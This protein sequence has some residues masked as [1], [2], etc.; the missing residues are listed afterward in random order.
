MSEHMNPGLLRQ[1][2]EDIAH[3][4][5]SGQGDE[6]TLAERACGLFSKEIAQVAAERD[7]WIAEHSSAVNLLSD[8]IDR[9]CSA[10]HAK[11]KHLQVL[12]D[13]AEAAGWDRGSTMQGLAEFVGALRERAEKAEA[14]NDSMH[15]VVGALEARVEKAE[16]IVRVSRKRMEFIADERDDWMRQASENAKRA[17]HAEFKAKQQ[18][19]PVYGDPDVRNQYDEDGDAYDPSVGWN[20]SFGCNLTIGYRGETLAVTVNTSDR[21]QRDGITHRTVTRQQVADYARKLLALVGVNE[22]VQPLPGDVVVTLHSPGSYDGD[23]QVETI[24]D[25]IERMRD[26][27][28]SNEIANTALATLRGDRS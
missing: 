13:V 11:Q 19:R 23:E 4:Q 2:R 21:D 22:F 25:A 17:N 8:A 12:A 1:L 10:E 16:A 7:Q 5:R 18:T 27:A 14:A 24:G 9:A 6:F 15:R 26:G 3:A 20:L 28:D